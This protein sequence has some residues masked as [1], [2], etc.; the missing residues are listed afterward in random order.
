MKRESDFERLLLLYKTEGKGISPK[1]YSINDGVIASLTE[2]TAYGKNETD[3]R[4]MVWDF[5]PTPSGKT[6]EGLPL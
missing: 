3:L 6:E 4:M 2:G 1:Q 5:S